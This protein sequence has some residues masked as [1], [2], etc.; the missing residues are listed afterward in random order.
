[1]PYSRDGARTWPRPEAG[2][3][4]KDHSIRDAVIPSDR[5]ISPDIHAGRTKDDKRVLQLLM[6]LER[7]DRTLKGQVFATG[8]RKPTEG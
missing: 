4:E 8:I 2:T 1:M 5:K 7:A 6:P 3:H